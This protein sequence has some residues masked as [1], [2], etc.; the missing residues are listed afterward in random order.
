MTSHCQKCLMTLGNGMYFLVVS[1]FPNLTWKRKFSRFDRCNF[2][3]YILITNLFVTRY[4]NRAT[5]RVH[6][7]TENMYGGKIYFKNILRVII[8]CFYVFV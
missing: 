3:L 7:S 1:T 4:C 6:T 2:I 5:S 8:I